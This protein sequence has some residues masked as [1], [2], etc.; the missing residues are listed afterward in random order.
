LE[1]CV[2]L[3]EQCSVEERLSRRARWL[4]AAVAVTLGTGI[5]TAVASDLREESTRL[6]DV[7]PD[8]F[9]AIGEQATGAVCLNCHGWDAIFG[10]PRQTPGQWDFIVSDM[11]GRGAQGTPEQLD[12]IRRYL[13]WVWGVVW[14]NSA[15]AQDLAAVTGMP[16]EDAKAVIAWREEHGA[17]ADL[18]SLKEVPGIDPDAIDEQADAIKFN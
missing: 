3:L 9:N 11:V 2:K 8:A 17:F 7:G 1:N 13:K 4:A 12:L 5:T 16:E 6:E 10:G 15:T 14:I 18:E